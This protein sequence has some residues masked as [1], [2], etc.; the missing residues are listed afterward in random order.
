MTRAQRSPSETVL[1]NL[2]L[3]L[4]S[5]ILLALPFLMPALWWLHYV[6]L[7]PWIILITGEER[8]L[9]WL[10]FFAG[11][12]TFFI[13]AFGALSLFHKAVPFAVAALYAP[14]LIPFA[15]L[16]RVVYRQLR[17]P[18]TLLVPVVWVATEWLRL[19]FSLG[20]MGFFPL[21]SSQFNRTT[22]IQIADITGL[23]GI[24]FLVAGANGMVV[25]LGRL[26]RRKQHPY[27]VA[28]C[29]CYGALVLA[30]L[31]DRKSVV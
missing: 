8:R 24:S 3:S 21:G 9:A 20:E 31:E 1:E 28:A 29:A 6:A 16:L 18:L 15:I 25:D 26:I 19:H 17:L 30:A 23:Y 14:F 2:A 4:L 7:I 22:L 10:Y 11:A 5:G 13:M 12:Y 27:T